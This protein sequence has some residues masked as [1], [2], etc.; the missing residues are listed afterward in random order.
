VSRTPV[1]AV[2]GRPNVGKSSLVNRILGRRVA[3]VDER[4]G[5]TRDRREFVADW[6]GH[7]FLI[8]DTGGW[9]VSPQE[10]LVAAIS[11]QAEAAL[12]SADVVLFVV[13]ATAGVS[14]D[15]ARVAR[16]LREAPVLLVANKVDGVGQE[17]DV[18]DLWQLGLGE[19]VPVSALHGRGV[20][21][22]LDKIVARLPE[23]FEVTS[24]ELRKLA[25]IGRPN[26]GKS[27]L[28]N[29]LVREDRVLVSP[30]PGTTRDPIDVVAT[31]GETRYRVVDTAG[32]RRAPKVKDSADYYSVLRAR[33]ALAEADVALLLV[34]GADQIVQQD[35]RIAEAVVESG[36]GLIVLVNKWD[37]PSRDDRETITVDVTDRLGFVGWAP[38]LRVSALTG[39]GLHRLGPALDEVFESRTTRVSTGVLNRLVREW[40]EAHPAPTRKGRRPRILYAVQAGIEPP[41][42]ILFVG[43]G[44]LD[45]SYLRYLERKLREEFPFIGTPVR[46]V[47]RRRKPPPR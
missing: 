8:V 33:G 11:E 27:T 34:D 3:V 10:E 25:I 42:F 13:D 29:R 39:R 14:E 26:V 31:I 41:T 21:D 2:V 24:E 23:A 37:V 15:D 28:L 18:P 17:P 38:M 44:E 5:V 20:G 7:D 6:A 46:L 43:G 47:A 16:L 19:P 9:E 40:Q 4:P 36:A 1:V 45:Q 32:I 35:Q 30:V 12:G 22:L